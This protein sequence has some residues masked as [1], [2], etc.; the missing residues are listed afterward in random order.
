MLQPRNRN[1]CAS[2]KDD[3]FHFNEG[4]SRKRKPLTPNLQTIQLYSHGGVDDFSRILYIGYSTTEEQIG[5]L[6]KDDNNVQLSTIFITHSSALRND[7]E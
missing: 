6:T 2:R 3:S 1:A 5:A 7:S 4:S